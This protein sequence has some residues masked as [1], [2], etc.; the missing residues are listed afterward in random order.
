[1]DQVAEFKNG[2][3]VVLEAPSFPGGMSSVFIRDPQG[4]IHDKIKCDS[5]T[6][7]RE[8]F[9]AFKKIAKNL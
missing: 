5:R 6:Q 2:A 8:Y 1:M 7:A 3:Y 9:R 4:N